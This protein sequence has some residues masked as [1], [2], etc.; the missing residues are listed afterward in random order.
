MI[1]SR[2]IRN[3]KMQRAIAVARQVWF[4][5]RG[6]RIEMYG[7]RLRYV[8]G[9]RPVRL[10]YRNDP[11]LT[12]RNDVRQ[13]EFFGENVK[14]GDFVIDIGANVGQYAVL[15]GAL[16][17]PRGKVI[18]FEPERGAR[19]LLESNVALNNLCPRVKVEPFAVCD[20]EGERSFYSRDG[21][22]MSSL[23]RAGFGTNAGLSDIRETRVQTVSFDSYLASN[24]LPD[25]Q[26]LKIDAEGAEIQV[27]KSARRAL[28]GRTKI[29]CELHPYAWDSFG[30]TF[31]E[32]RKLVESFGRRMR[33]LDESRDISN[34]PD[35][36]A[37][38]IDP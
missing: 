9:T 18:A 37:V 34:G 8:P 7:H 30:N 21:D 11:D 24:C 12:V 29:L 14:Q 6:E 15:L 31:D 36:G 5:G 28:A 3:S 20:S 38:I 2:I 23:H 19:A 17:G 4:A 10:K 1:A 22:M 26:W 35:Y 25:P 32:L 13:L 27:L 33:F 16:V